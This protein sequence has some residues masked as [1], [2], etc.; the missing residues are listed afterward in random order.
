MNGAMYRLWHGNIVLPPVNVL[1]GKTVY[2][3]GWLLFKKK[4]TAN[5][6]KM[7]STNFCLTNTKSV[8]SNVKMFQA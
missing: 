2:V 1:A 8:D 3:V 6:L 7:V 5:T 4:P